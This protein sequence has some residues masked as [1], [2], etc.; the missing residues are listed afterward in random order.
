MST[1][2]ARQMEDRHGADLPAMSERASD[3]AGY[4]PSCGT[5]L[6]AGSDDS[7]RCSRPEQRPPPARRRATHRSRFRLAVA[8]L[9]VR[10]RPLDAGRPDR[11]RGDDRACSSASSCPGS[12]SHSVS[13]ADRS[14]GCGTGGC[15]S[16]LILCI[17]IVAY[18]V[19]RAGWDKLP[20]AQD[21]PHLTVM[22]VAT[23]VNLVLVVIAFIDKPGGSGVGWGVRRR[24]RPHRGGSC[25][26]ALRDA[27][28]ARQNNV[29]SAADGRR[30]ASAW[31][32]ATTQ[33]SSPPTARPRMTRTDA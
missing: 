2:V 30:S 21:V 24:P 5:A 12:P 6:S 19:L 1:P 4:C 10:R 23:I 32:R 9:Q 28:T 14:T 11:R 27:A 31:R 25:G 7:P 29:A 33:G 8:G 18:L 16:A 17:V 15:T 26:R 20:I 13:P 3:E 22:M